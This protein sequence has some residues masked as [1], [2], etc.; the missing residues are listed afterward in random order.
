MFSTESKYGIY[1]YHRGFL[2][3]DAIS[4]TEGQVSYTFSFTEEDVLKN[5]VARSSV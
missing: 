1:G 3:W 4:Y 2:Q 5:A